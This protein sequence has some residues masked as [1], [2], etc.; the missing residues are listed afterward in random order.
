[1]T[2]HDR[3]NAKGFPHGAEVRL[4]NKRV[5]VKVG[6]DRDGDYVEI[7]IKW[8]GWDRVTGRRSPQV[9]ILRMSLESWCAARAAVD[10]TCRTAP[11]RTN[12]GRRAKG[13]SDAMSLFCAT[14][15]RNAM[16]RA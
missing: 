1:M 2:K 10:A 16:V 7:A 4:K 14:G 12:T 15:G 5:R 11:T 6:T 8:L 13:V 9:Q 3:W